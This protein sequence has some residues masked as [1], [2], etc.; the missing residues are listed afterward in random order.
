MWEW[1]NPVW[2]ILGILGIIVGGVWWLQGQFTQQ[3]TYIFEQIEKL[4]KAIASKLE[5]HEQHDDRRFSEIKRDV[6]DIRL[7][8]AAID[9]ETYVNRE[10]LR[11][12]IL[13]QSEKENSELS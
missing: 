8:N 9:G 6:I 7:R 13:E 1:I 5:Y 12:V 4:E 11:K 2:N 10:K 3:K